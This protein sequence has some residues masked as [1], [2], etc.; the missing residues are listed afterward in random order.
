MFWKL[1]ARLRGDNNNKESATIN[2]EQWTEYFNGLHN[3]SLNVDHDTTFDDQIKNK[4]A[5]LTQVHTENDPSKNSI[6]EGALHEAAKNLKN[7]KSCIPDSILNEMIKVGFKQLSTC[8]SKLCNA[9]INTEVV[10]NDWT[11]GYIVLLHKGGAESV[12]S[13]YRGIS[14]TSCLEKLFSAVLCKRLYNAIE[15]NNLISK[16]QIVFVKGKRTSDH[17]FVLKSVMR[18]RG[19][20]G[21]RY[22]LK[23]SCQIHNSEE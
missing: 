11:R 21:R 5:T 8:I 19:G 1:L 23:L 13:N 7:N 2:M 14:I 17:I 3:I 22:N 6:S 16:S 15:T 4:L 9:I 10:P 20:G 12:T 18:E